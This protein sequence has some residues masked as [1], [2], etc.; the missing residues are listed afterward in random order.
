MELLE[1]DLSLP[2][3]LLESHVKQVWAALNAAKMIIGFRKKP[4]SLTAS[5]MSLKLQVRKQ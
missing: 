2:D 5:P 1:V 3:S 4:I